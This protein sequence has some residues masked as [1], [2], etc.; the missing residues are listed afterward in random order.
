[1]QLRLVQTRQL[2]MPPIAAGLQRCPLFI[3]NICIFLFKRQILFIFTKYFISFKSDLIFTN[4]F[5]NPTY[6]SAALNDDIYD[7]VII[8]KIIEILLLT[9][10]CLIHRDLLK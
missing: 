5:L 1:M 6:I 7:K 8:L 10:H 4:I 2:Y 9:T 3:F